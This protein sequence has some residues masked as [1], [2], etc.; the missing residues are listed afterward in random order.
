MGGEGSNVGAV[1][2][3]DAVSAACLPATVSFFLPRPKSFF[4]LLRMLPSSLDLV[5]LDAVA[6]DAGGLGCGGAAAV[7]LDALI[8]VPLEMLRWWKRWWKM[9]DVRPAQEG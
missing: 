4:P 5:S 1:V 7:L 9:R 6:M 2:V 8:L 3:V